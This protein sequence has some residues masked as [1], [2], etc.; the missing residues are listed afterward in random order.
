MIIVDNV[1]QNFKLQQENGI[2]IKSWFDDAEDTALYELGPLLEKIRLMKFTD[3]P[4]GLKA[5]IEGEDSHE[6]GS[7]SSPH[8]QYYDGNSEV[9]ESKEMALM[10]ALDKKDLF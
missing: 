4:Q 10:Q 5:V 2:H 8:R 6:P 3:L 1:A 9:E 7:G